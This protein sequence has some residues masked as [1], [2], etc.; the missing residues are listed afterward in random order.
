MPAQASPPGTA[1]AVGAIYLDHHATTPVHPEVW[2]E[3]GSFATDLFFN[4]S[5]IYRG[6][7]VV[8]DQLHAAAETVRRYLHAPD[9]QVV[10]TSGAT[11]ANNLSLKC[12]A[13]EADRA[14]LVSPTE[15]KSVI[16]TSAYLHRSRRGRVLLR[17]DGRGHVDLEDLEARLRAGASL[18]S[19]MAVNN[20]IGTAARVREVAALCLAHGALFHCDATQA[21]DT[22][23]L[24]LRET[25]ADLVT[26][27]AHKIYGPKGA[28]CLVVSERALERFEEPHIHGGGQQQGLRAGTENVMG[29]MGM[30]RALEIAA[31]DLERNVAHRRAMRDR[32]QAG[33]AERC[34]VVVNG[35]PE[36][37]HPGNLHVSFR[38]VVPQRFFA[39]CSSIAFST[40]SACNSQSGETSHVLRAI[41]LTAADIKASMRL[42]VGI[43]TTEADVDAAVEIL[44]SAAR[45]ARP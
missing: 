41:G 34:E 8:Q 36:R 31:R 22:F 44:E 21:M 40:G 14:M 30:A 9:H 28:G 12:F 33:L 1:P 23:P 6:S 24:D 7:L 2:A 35:D 17:V 11:E 20:E 10:F 18:V 13:G 26:F 16:A 3:M 32:L 15:H 27:S 19:V 5:G 29:I 38:G 25:P 4:P 39:R 43:S 45:Q 42:S 37:R